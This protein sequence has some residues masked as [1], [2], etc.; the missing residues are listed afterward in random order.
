MQY[1]FFVVARCHYTRYFSHALQA[2]VNQCSAMSKLPWR[3]NGKGANQG[4]PINF[5]PYKARVANGRLVSAEDD[6]EDTE[7]AKE[8]PRLLLVRHAQSVSNAR[9][10]WKKHVAK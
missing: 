6:T 4:W 2:L 7:D 9:G 3:Q 5:K 8:G 1:S 10:D